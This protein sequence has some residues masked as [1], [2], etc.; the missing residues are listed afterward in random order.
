MY[1][2]FEVGAPS[3]KLWATPISTAMTVTAP[4]SVVK[5]RHLVAQ[6][7]RQREKVRRTAVQPQYVRK[8]R[9]TIKCD[10]SAV[11]TVA[12]NT[13]L[14]VW[15]SVILDRYWVCCTHGCETCHASPSPDRLPQSTISSF[16]GSHSACLSASNN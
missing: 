10:R 12:K 13:S 5:L 16:T 7:E 6:P 11:L 8:G 4:Q 2:Y 1:L 14:H 3:L 15:Q 9:P